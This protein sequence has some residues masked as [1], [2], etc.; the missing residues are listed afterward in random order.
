MW[1]IL[2]A[3][4]PSDIRKVP[5][6]QSKCTKKFQTSTFNVWHKIMPSRLHRP[7]TTPRPQYIPKPYLQNV[8]RVKAKQMLVFTGHK[9]I[10]GPNIFPNHIC[11]QCHKQTATFC[12]I[13]QMKLYACTLRTAYGRTRYWQRAEAFKTIFRP[14]ACAWPPCSVIAGKAS[15]PLQQALRAQIMVS[16]YDWSLS[17]GAYGMISILSQV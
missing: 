3:I 13:E 8:T 15:Q 11:K 14:C 10:L 12:C 1:W 2:W 4:K 5:T 6:Q 9:T 16:L 7:Q 17:S